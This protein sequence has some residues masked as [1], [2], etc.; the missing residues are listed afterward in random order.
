MGQVLHR[1]LLKGWE[2]V[3]AKTNVHNELVEVGRFF[4]GDRGEVW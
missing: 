1:S 3:G 4:D 2:P